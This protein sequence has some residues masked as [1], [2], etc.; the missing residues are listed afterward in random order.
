MVIVSVTVPIVTL[1]AVLIP[2]LVC[3]F[4]HGLYLLVSHL[5]SSDVAHA[6]ARVVLTL[7][8]RACHIRLATDFNDTCS[9]NHPM[10]TDHVESTEHV[11]LVD[12]ISTVPVKACVR[13]V[14]V[15]RVSAMKDDFNRRKIHRWP[16]H[17]RLKSTA[18]QLAPASVRQPMLTL[19]VLAVPENSMLEAVRLVA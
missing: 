5:G 7:T 13:F 4:I 17:S 14:K 12:V 6:E 16:T 11:P 9:S 15:R 18:V 3:Q 8:V 10:V 1:Y 2:D 19:D